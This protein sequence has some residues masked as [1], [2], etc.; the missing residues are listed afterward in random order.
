M[1]LLEEYCRSE[2]EMNIISPTRA[3]ESSFIPVQSENTDPEMISAV[4][5]ND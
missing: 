4:S 2:V 5:I 3:L 1:A